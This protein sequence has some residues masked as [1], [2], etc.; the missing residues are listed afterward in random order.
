M[1]RKFAQIK[2]TIW[3][4][5]DFR[6]L[7][8]LE[9]HLY[10]VVLTAKSMTHCGVADWRPGR[11]G[12]HARGW[13]ADQVED[14]AAGLIE[15]LY[16]VVDESTEEVLVRSFVRHEE[17]MKQPKMAVAVA[18]AHDDVAS[19]PLRGVVVHELL[20]LREDFPELSCWGNTKVAETLAKASVNP[21]GYPLG[22]G[23]VKGIGTLSDRGGERGGQHL[24][25][26][27]TPSTSHLSDSLRSSGAAAPS[28]VNAQTVV[29]VWVDA[30]REAAGRQPSG[31]MR[32]QAGKDA[33]ALLADAPDPLLV[34]EAAKA[35]GAKGFATIEREY[36]PLVAR[37]RIRPVADDDGYEP[38]Q[39]PR[40][41]VF[42]D[43]PSALQRWHAEQRALWEAGRSS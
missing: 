3:G 5:D 2:L 28:D 33:K 35:A 9:Q 41:I 25:P 15:K 29:G 31:G 21:S 27:P 40:E 37:S 1:A 20:R 14:T 6:D 13:S 22:K 4:D 39:A 17:L 34:V 8:P 7:T 16:F 18:T 36:G 38:P 30:Y 11:I 12:A 19:G 32:A 10:F 26:T 42:A 23:S 24:A 43:D